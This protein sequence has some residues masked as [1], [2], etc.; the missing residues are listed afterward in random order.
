MLLET[1]G[2]FPWVG[3]FLFYFMMPSLLA[4][5]QYRSPRIG[6]LAVASTVVMMFGYGIGF[7]EAMLGGGLHKKRG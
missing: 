1:L 4:G 6:F 7:L 2:T 3:L 5:M